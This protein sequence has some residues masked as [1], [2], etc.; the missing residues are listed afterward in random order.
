M[1]RFSLNDLD[2][3]FESIEQAVQKHG[4]NNVASDIAKAVHTFEAAM[5]K[6]PEAERLPPLTAGEWM[7]TFSDSDSGRDGEMGEGI[8]EE[9]GE[10]EIPL[11]ES[12]EE[13]S[14]A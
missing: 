2:E 12:D 6:L 3:D 14:E 7:D 13:D 4:A 11:E 10:E 5:A 9:G 1:V 8:G